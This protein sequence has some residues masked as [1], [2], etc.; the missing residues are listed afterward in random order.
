MGGL[1]GGRWHKCYHNK[2]KGKT[3]K[4]SNVGKMATGGG[5]SPL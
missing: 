5:F 1:G 3:L 2:A 4:N